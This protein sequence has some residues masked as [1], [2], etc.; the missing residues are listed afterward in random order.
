MTGH[1]WPRDYRKQR[2]GK[3]IKDG[4]AGACDSA[5][6]ESNQNS[7]K[8]ESEKSANDVHDADKG[9]DEGIIAL[10]RWSYCR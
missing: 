6:K 7:K 5:D 8:V 1:S 9:M 10:W 2:R 3:S 4:E